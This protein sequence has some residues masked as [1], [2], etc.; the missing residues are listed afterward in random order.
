MRRIAN[1]LTLCLGALLIAACAQTAVQFGPA[2][3]PERT[4]AQVIELHL[5]EP[6]KYRWASRTLSAAEL[7]SALENEA[8]LTPIAEIHLLN[9]EQEPSPGNL[10]ELGYLA[11]ALGAKAKYQ[12]KGQWQTVTITD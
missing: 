9:G 1:Y 7:Q 8:G 6:G 11:K 5:A 2:P 10:L 4:V 12:R 3:E